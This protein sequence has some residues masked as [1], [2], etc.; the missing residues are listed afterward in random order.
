MARF[1][2]ARPAQIDLVWPTSLRRAPSG[3]ASRAGSGTQPFSWLRCAKLRLSPKGHSQ[4]SDLNSVLMS[5]ASMSGTH[6][7]LLKLLRSEGR[8]TFSTIA[9]LGT[10]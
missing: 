6:D 4:G 10:A 9:S 7:V 8:F 3:G 5:E 2:L 1:R